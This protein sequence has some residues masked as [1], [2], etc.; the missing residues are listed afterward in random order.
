MVADKHSLVEAG[1]VQGREGGREVLHRAANDAH[2][3][4]VA[5]VL[6]EHHLGGLLLEVAA[7]VGATQ[8]SAEA[9]LA[10]SE[11]VLGGVVGA[12]DDGDDL[13]VGVSTSGVAAD[14]GQKLIHL[15]ARPRAHPTAP[16]ANHKAL[17]N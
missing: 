1:W 5:E 14:G 6:G 13:T 3:S 12:R 8:A 2:V 11:E 4:G 10:A 16:D 9:L 15:V 17:A 7:E